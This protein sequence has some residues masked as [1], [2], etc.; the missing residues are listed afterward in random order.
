MIIS[1]TRFPVKVCGTTRRIALPTQKAQ[2]TIGR[3][4]EPFFTTRP[5]G[6][7]TGLGLDTVYQ[8]VRKHQGEISFQSKP[9]ATC[10]QARLPLA[11]AQKQ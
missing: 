11:L 9:G 6:E 10:F 8:I 1:V 4:F 7:G 3:I 2:R 5:Q